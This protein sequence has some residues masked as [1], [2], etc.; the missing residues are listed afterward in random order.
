MDKISD[1]MVYHKIVGLI[2]DLKLGS[3]NGSY[4]LATNTV[5]IIQ[6]LI[7]QYMWSNVSE[8]IIVI[9][10][11]ADEVITA[12]PTETV[13]GNMF[14]RVLKIIRDEFAN[15]RGLHNEG[16]IEE[17]LQKMI[18]T[19]EEPKVNYEINSEFLKESIND[20][21]SELLSELEMSVENIAK[22]SLEHI[23]F[24]EVIMTCGKSKTVEAFLKYAAKKKRRF[25]VVIAECAPFYNG[26]EL[27]VSL[28]NEKI[29]TT[30]IPDSAI[31]AIMSRVNKVIIGSHSVMANG[32][33]K[34]VSGA[35]TLALAAKH[36]SVPLIVC[37]AM[38]KLTPQYLVSH[39]QL[40]FNKFSSPQQV[41]PYEEPEMATDCQVVNPVF[42]YVPPELVTVFV[43]N[44]GGNSPSYVYRLLNELYHTEDY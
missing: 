17:S 20:S 44:I 12:E 42:D 39:D 24:E 1:L 26:H 9:K 37:T 41:M 4:E 25:Q 10:E 34:A 31:F 13:T 8:L 5:M 32:G 40:A 28:S 11:I 19:D 38:F 3:T 35:Y 33:L 22:Q 36:Y 15:A 14:K 21:I 43:S 18:T 29:N 6:E 2:K 23:Y 16:E 27:A 30:I 7:D